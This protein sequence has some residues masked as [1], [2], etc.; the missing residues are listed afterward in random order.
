[1][2]IIWYSL[3]LYFRYPLSLRQVA[4][5]LEFRGIAV[6]H[7]SIYRWIIKF[8]PVLEEKFRKYKLPVSGSWRVNETYI[9]VK[10]EWKYLYRAVD[11][12]GQTIDFLLSAKRDMK[13]AKRFFK[14]AIRHNGQ[15]IKTTIDKSGANLAGIQAV[16]DENRHQIEI[17]QIKYL[18]NI[19]EQDHRSIKRQV[20]PMLG[21]KE[22]FS[23]KI[24]IAGIEIMSMI[25]K[26]QSGYMPL[27]DRTPMAAFWAIVKT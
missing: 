1:M 8:G 21:F 13:A 4:E 5:M 16:N 23:A 25:F 19:I 26:G 6:D 12:Y 22:F 20:N 10:A 18:N 7:S 14:K 27:I 24:I 9:K 15:P 3:F 11:K 2:E 17:R